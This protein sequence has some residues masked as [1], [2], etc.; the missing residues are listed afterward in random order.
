[1]DGR[2]LKGYIKV[3]EILA[4]PTTG[5]LLKAGQWLIHQRWGMRNFIRYQGLSDIKD[6]LE[7]FLLKLDLAR[8][9]SKVEA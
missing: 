1:M 7:R 8:M 5:F 6:D 4:K 2:L 9:N 3:R